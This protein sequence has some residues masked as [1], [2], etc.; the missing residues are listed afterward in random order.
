MPPPSPRPLGVVHGYGLAGAG[1]NLWTRAILRAL[2]QGGH[3]VHA[4][5][6]ESAPE[7][8]D[9]VSKAIAYDADGAPRVLFDRD[10]PTPGRVV[11]HRPDLDVLPTYVR[12]ST[13]S[14]YVVYIPD[15]GDDAVEGYVER[16]ARVLRAVAHAEGVAGWVVNHTVLMAVAAHRARQAGGAPY[17]VLPHGSAIE[18]VVKQEER[19]MRLAQAALAGAA[20]VFALNGEM[21]GRIRDVFGGLEAKTGRMPVGTDTSVFELVDRADRSATVERIARVVDGVERGRPADATAALHA[22]L[23]ALGDAPSDADVLAALRADYPRSAPDADVEAKLR[24][25]DWSRAKTVVY[26]GR[27]IAA[28]GPADLVLALPLVAERHPETVALVAGT[29]GLREGLEA[30]VWALS[31]GRGSLVRRLVRLGG[32]LEGGGGLDADPFF[33]GQAFLDGLDAA[34]TFDDY[35]ATAHRALTPASVVFTGFLDHDALGPLYGLADAG[36]FPSVVREASPLVVP[37]SAAAGVL[38]VGPDVG[39]MGDSLRTLAEGL[40]PEARP[41]VTTR[42]EAEHRIPDLADRL[43]SALDAPR[44]FAADLR[45]EAE[46]RFDWRAIAE[47]LAA[48]LSALG[49]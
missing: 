33:A 4:V 13:P 46:A 29:G 36:A 34:G 1:S 45:R 10:T 2:A 7:R 48:E 15:L 19:S 21:E 35:L 25:V 26:V 27:L 24:A 6:Q 44:A 39:G 42:P 20:R 40:P 23:A 5:C 32:A 22:R 30:L 49:D 37:E 41:L 9:F 38:P 11:V 43:V 18:Y 31:E 12:P 17:A 3:T 16:N 8:Y 14:D 47:R 28:K